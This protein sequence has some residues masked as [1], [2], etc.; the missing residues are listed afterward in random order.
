MTAPLEQLHDILPGPP[1][2]AGDD[3]YMI[4]YIVTS[5]LALVSFI[6][7]KIWP[8]YK[9]YWR[10]KKELHNILKRNPDNCVPA[11]NQLIKEIACYYWP[12]EQYAKLHTMDWL[13]FLDEHSSCQFRNFSG[14]WEAWSYSTGHALSAHDRNAVIREC[15]R[16]FSNVCR[17][18]PLS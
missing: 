9:I 12:R 8:R 15:K 10:A 2:D 3:K 17:R 11:I 7:Y 4:I 5:V 16:W 13:K 14:Q 6:C 1:L 18:V